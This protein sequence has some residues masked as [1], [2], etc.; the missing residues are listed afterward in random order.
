MIKK[1]LCFF[2]GSL[3][4]TQVAKAQPA[5]AFLA[6]SGTYTPIAGGTVATINSGDFDDGF[7]NAIP[8]GFIFNYNGINYTTISGSANGWVTFGQSIA[9]TS[10][11]NDIAASG[12]RPVLAVLYEDLNLGTN[13]N[14]TYTTTGTPGNQVFTLQW[15]NLLWDYAATTPSIS[16]Q[17]KLYEGTNVIEFIYRQEAGAVQ[18]NNS[19]GASIGITAAAT[20]SGSYLSLSDASANPVIS[21]T[22]ATNTIPTRPA[23]GQVYRWSPYCA[24]STTS[25][26]LE[27]ISNVSFAN[28]NNNSTSTAGYENFTN[29]VAQVQPSSSVPIS[30]TASNAIATDQVTMYIDFN[31]NGLFTDPGETVYTSTQ[32]TGPFVGTVNIPAISANV[33]LGPTRVRVRLQNAA[34]AGANATPCGNASFGQVEDYMVDIEF[35]SAAN[36]TTQPP[37]TAICNGGTGSIA[38]AA[39]GNNLTYQWQLSTDNG[40]TFNDVSNGSTYSGV[41]TNTLVISGVNPSMAN[42][43]YRA[44]INGLCTPAN[45]LSSAAVLSI[46]TPAAITTNPVIATVCAGS[47]A[48]F[49]VAASGTSPTYQWQVSTDGGITYNNISGAT[50]ST[51]PFSAVAQALNGNRYRAIATVATCGSVTSAAAILT[52]N[53]LPVVTISTAPESQVRPGDSTFVTVGA[54]P[55]AVSYIWTLNG[56]VIAGANTNS[57]VANSL[58]MGA[59]QVTVTD[60]NGCKNTSQSL[61]VD[62]RPTEK[63][64]IYPNPSTGKF[65]VNLYSPWLSDVRTVTIYNSAGAVVVTKYFEITG[66][67]MEMKFDLSGAA[68]GLYVVRV[69]HYYVN[70]EV[71]GKLILQ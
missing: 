38:I 42:Y 61:T 32:G 48:S 4:L 56:N 47:S 2:L 26:T 19:G 36:I 50:A 6:T 5:Y 15:A 68:A 64:F 59:Y 46:N 12:T 11:T 7:S 53:A 44:R 14:F 21:S 1:L 65:T 18:L 39:T 66:N 51:L 17:L 52:V 70:K 67:Y 49:S 10:S 9:T 71:V 22:V 16:M 28:I 41:T 33:L 25:A 13:A 45:T 37:N 24:A 31:R 55:G 60:I 54:V 57:V 20:G 63:L 30:V 40:A 29:L 3:L 23:T 8:I 69:T 27:K 62:P 35:C 43:R 34:D 58:S